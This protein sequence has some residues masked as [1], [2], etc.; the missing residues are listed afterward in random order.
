M[1]AFPTITNGFVITT[2]SPNV[3]YSQILGS[4][5]AYSYKIKQIY[6]YA[7][8]LSQL[9]TTYTFSKQTP[10]GNALSY[11]NSITPS[12]YQYQ[13]AYYWDFQDGGTVIFDNNTFFQFQLNPNAF[14]QMMLFVDFNTPSNKLP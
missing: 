6:L 12:P 14:N 9:S 7:N 8:D 11:P 13:N 2:G 10:D 5:S 4:L 1:P 3:S